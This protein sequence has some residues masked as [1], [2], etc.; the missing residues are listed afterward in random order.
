MLAPP[1]TLG[2]PARYKVD[3]SNSLLICVMLLHH[4]HSSSSIEVQTIRIGFDISTRQ[5]QAR[6]ANPQ[7]ASDIR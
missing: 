6:H 1:P 2:N 3:R 4:S 5:A 7:K